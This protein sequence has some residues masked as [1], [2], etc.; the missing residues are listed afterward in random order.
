M[1]ADRF[2]YSKDFRDFLTVLI[3]ER[4]IDGT[5]ILTMTV[6]FSP[7][8]KHGQLEAAIVAETMDAIEANRHTNFEGMA[9]AIRAMEKWGISHRENA[10]PLVAE[11]FDSFA[12]WS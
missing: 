1:D 8:A 4:I 3:E 9:R 11:S 12:S 10:R 6:H 2:S 5:E 7:L